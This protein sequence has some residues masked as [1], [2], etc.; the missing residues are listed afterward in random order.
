MFNSHRDEIIGKTLV[1]TYLK[2]ELNNFLK[3]DRQVLSDGIENIS[4]ESITFK[5]NPNKTILTRKTRYVQV[6]KT[7]FSRNYSRCY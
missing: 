6:M 1:K 4:E 2:K 5:N 3:I 7:V